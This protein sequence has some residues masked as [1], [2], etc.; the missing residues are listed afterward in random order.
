MGTNIRLILTVWLFVFSFA[1]MA[2]NLS[3][4]E[5]KKPKPLQHN[6]PKHSITPML[7]LSN[8]SVS[9][10]LLQVSPTLQCKFQNGETLNTPIAL[11]Y[12]Y[13]MKRGNRIGLDYLNMYSSL[14]F[15]P[16]TQD[17]TFGFYGPA[18]PAFSA[19]LQGANLHFSKAIDIKLLEV[20]G[21]VGV[22]G[23][24]SGKQNPMT[25]D[26]SWYKNSTAEFYEFAP[27]ATHNVIKPFIPMLNFGAGV[28]LKHLE[29]GINN[30]FSLSSPVKNIQ[31]QGTTF[32][33]NMRLK[34]IGYYIA[35]RWEF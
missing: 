6:P 12:Q 25:A 19:N 23:Y 2:A 3:A 31:Y 29:G 8:T 28:R 7:S 16:Q 1:A 27:A 4:I 13:R 30:Q 5:S 32:T 20:F 33:N 22:G 9:E 15:R 24:L 26:Y 21:F 11:R 18:V 35:Y 17:N 10:F 14:M 34:S